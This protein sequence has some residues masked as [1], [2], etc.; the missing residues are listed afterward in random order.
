VVVVAFLVASDL[1]MSPVQQ[2]LWLL[3]PLSAIAWTSFVVLMLRLG[4]LAAIVAVWTANLL[5]VPA[6]LYAP[7]SWTGSS[8]VVVVPLALALAVFAFRSAAGGHLGLR[9]HL[10]GEASSARSA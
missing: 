7:G 4:V 10:T 3:L 2:N 5:Q 6:V 9:R 8:A 1:L